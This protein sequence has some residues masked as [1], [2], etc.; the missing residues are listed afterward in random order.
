MNR[1]VYHYC[2]VKREHEVITKHL[3]GI[4]SPTAKI[5]SF[6]DYQKLKTQI[7]VDSGWATAAGITVT[8]LSFMGMEND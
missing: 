4:A 8:S 5:T 3:D 7:A 1:F 2:A 6:S